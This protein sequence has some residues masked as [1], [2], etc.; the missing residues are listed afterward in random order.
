MS[1]LGKVFGTD[2]AVENVIKQGKEL[3]DDAF[4]TDSEKAEEK[5]AAA[6]AVRSMV[7]EWM[8]NSQGQ[9]LARRVIAMSVTFTWLGGFIIAGLMAVIAVWTDTYREPLIA[10]SNLIDQRNSGMSGAVM[11]ILGFYFAAPKISE[12]AEAAM[13]RFGSKQP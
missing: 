4:Y 6:A 2:A 11:L 12:I 5:A 13:A 3:L 7:V 9:N 10:S 1:W 8:Q